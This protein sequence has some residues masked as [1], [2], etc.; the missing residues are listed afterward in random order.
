MTQDDAVPGAEDGVPT[1]PRPPWPGPGRYTLVAWAELEVAL[2]QGVRIDAAHALISDA[3]HDAFGLRLYEWVSAALTAEGRDPEDLT[4]LLGD[5]GL[6]ERVLDQV[7]ARMGED[8][9]APDPPDA[10]YAWY[11]YSPGD[12]AGGRE[13]FRRAVR[14]RR[15]HAR[16]ALLAPPRPRVAGSRDR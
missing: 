9:G 2:E 11:A 1:L 12:P 4:A 6:A 8:E 14:R 15:Q 5:D 3:V 7:L 13:R 16:D 10:E